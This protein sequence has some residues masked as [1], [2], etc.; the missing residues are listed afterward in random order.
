MTPAPHRTARQA[1]VAALLLSLPAAALAIVPLLALM[2]K[3]IVQDLVL[4]EVKGQLIQSLA[5]M[6]C[7]GARLASLVAS[8]SVP[9]GP[10]GLSGM[11]GLTGMGGLAGMGSPPGAGNVPGMDHLAGMS[12]VPAGM[13]SGMPTGMPSGMPTGMPSGM[14]TGMA[15]G[16]P[17]G[18]PAGIPTGM[19]SGGAVALGGA[20][21]GRSMGGALAMPGAGRMDLPTMSGAQAG[22]MSQVMAAMQARSGGGMSPEQMAMAQEAMAS[23]Q[24]A[25]EHPLTRP[26]T[27]AVFTDLKELGVLTDSMHS[28]VR[29]CILLAPPGSDR[30]LGQTGAI[31]KEVLLPKLHETKARLAS[32]S[33]EEQA[34]LAQGIAEALQQARPEDRKAFQEGLGLGFFPKPVVEQVEALA[35]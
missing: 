7:K 1:L 17:T 32:L 23:M 24:K 4:G 28:E 2:G 14:P 33:P 10:G 26:E 31:V 19:P 9:K 18:M 35:R 34:Q 6:G 8:T 11:G 20:G 12:G 5:S 25:M 27:L 13:P 3:Q 22:D 21:G 15:S 16:M 30:Q 29:D